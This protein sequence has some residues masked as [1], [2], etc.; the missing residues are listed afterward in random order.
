M[1]NYTPDKKKCFIQ[2]FY[3]EYYRSTYRL[4]NRL[5]IG[6]FHHDFPM[7]KFLLTVIMLNLRRYQMLLKF[8]FL[9]S[10]VEYDK[11]ICFFY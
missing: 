5:Y 11:K 7:F 6:V 8:K 1:V 9:F 2:V 4:E 3:T 10:T